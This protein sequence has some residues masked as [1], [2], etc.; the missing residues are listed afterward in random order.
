VGLP[1]LSGAAMEPAAVPPLVR[2]TTT[3]GK[4]METGI[5]SFD[6]DNSN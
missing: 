4:S 5:R 3:P 6:D 2:Q 1:D